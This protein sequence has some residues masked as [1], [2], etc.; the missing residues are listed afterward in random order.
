MS[1]H[2]NDMTKTTSDKFKYKK[3]HKQVLVII[4]ITISYSTTINHK[5]KIPTK[6]Y[7]F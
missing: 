7:K 1:F 5:G 3:S 4:K 6:K 2:Q